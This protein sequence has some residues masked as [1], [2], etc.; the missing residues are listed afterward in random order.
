MVYPTHYMIYTD[1]LKL[2][3]IIDKIEFTP[4]EF[5][6]YIE[7]YNKLWAELNHI[8]APVVPSSEEIK[9]KN[10]PNKKKVKG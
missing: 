3:G 5:E 2:A 4:E 6:Q 1:K 7:Q 8:S 10:S 9:S